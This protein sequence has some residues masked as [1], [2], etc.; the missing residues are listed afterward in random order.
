[1]ARINLRHVSQ[2]IISSSI[3]SIQRWMTADAIFCLLPDIQW[4]HMIADERLM[5]NFAQKCEATCLFWSYI[6]IY[7]MLQIVLQSF[8]QYWYW[9]ISLDCFGVS[10]FALPTFLC[11]I[12]GIPYL[13][14]GNIYLSWLIFAYCVIGI[15]CLFLPFP[16]WTR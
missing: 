9:I 6:N 1:M 5:L 16:R 2:N 10:F 3:G 14:M 4:Y 11:S 15:F 7:L 12:F 13:V 8:S